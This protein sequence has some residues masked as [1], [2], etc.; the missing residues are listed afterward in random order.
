MDT[1]KM[2]KRLPA[3]L[4]PL[5]LLTVPAHAADEKK[6][7]EAKEEAAREDEA[8]DEEAEEQE[9]SDLIPLADG[10][11]YRYAPDYCDFEITFPEKPQIMEKCIP[12]DECFTLYSYTMVYDLQTTV[13]VSVTCN[14]S[15]EA[16]YER[17]TQNVVKAA[18]AGMVDEK[19]LEEHSI[20]YDQQENYRS[21]GISG[22]GK[23]G[24]QDKI[25]TGQL[26]VGKNSVFTV[27][28]E[29]IGGEHVVADESFGIILSSIQYKGGKQV[30]Q[31]PAPSST[32]K[33]A[34]Q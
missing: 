27:Q 18:L 11:S 22:S 20:R 13:D 14:P 30:P 19:K 12:G 26:W 28:A 32:P 3:L 31:K 25:Y 9:P 5:W 16:N 17:Y 21:G 24:Q 8:D 4:I 10:K 2:K 23:T 1:K 15:S 7:D 33:G 34:N 6:K 29:L